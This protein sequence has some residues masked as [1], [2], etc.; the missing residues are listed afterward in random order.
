IE[1]DEAVGAPGRI[2]PAAAHDSEISSQLARVRPGERQ[3]D[4]PPAD[5]RAGSEITHQLRPPVTVRVLLT[6][7]K[8]SQ[9]GSSPVAQG[10]TG[11]EPVARV[12]PGRETPKTSFPS[13]GSG[14]LGETA[15]TRTNFAMLT[16]AT[17][18]MSWITS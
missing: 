16:P 12:L 2:P 1:Q 4:R 5:V 9:S 6:P 11:A 15:G 18:S 7:S 3:V 13:V 10:T 8:P 17:P 14:V